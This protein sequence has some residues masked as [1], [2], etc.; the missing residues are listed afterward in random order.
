MARKKR[1][2]KTSGKMPMTGMPPRRTGS[3]KVTPNGSYP[4]AHGGN[5]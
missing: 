4:M 2:S 3:A 1:S 5:C